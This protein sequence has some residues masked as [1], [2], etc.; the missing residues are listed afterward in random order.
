[1]AAPRVNTTNHQAPGLC[2][3]TEMNVGGSVLTLCLWGHRDQDGDEVWR[4]QS[5]ANRQGQ[6]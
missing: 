1:M 6:S 4:E 3:E 5:M 2:K